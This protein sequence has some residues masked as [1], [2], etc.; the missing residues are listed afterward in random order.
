MSPKKHLDATLALFF[1]L[2]CLKA[3][4]STQKRDFGRKRKMA[5][6]RQKKAFGAPKMTKNRKKKKLFSFFCLL[7]KHH[8]ILSSIMNDYEVFCDIM[9][10]T[11]A[12]NPYLVFLE[13][14]YLNVWMK[15]DI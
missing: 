12:G 5:N 7:S 8:L 3:T 14:F 1:G 13:Y 2:F 9:L 10:K 11:V 15:F 4:L 6:V